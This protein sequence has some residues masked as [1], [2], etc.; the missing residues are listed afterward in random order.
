MTFDDLAQW[1]SQLGA[2]VKLTATAKSQIKAELPAFIRDLHPASA[3]AR[4]RLPTGETLGNATRMTALKCQCIFLARSAFGADYVKLHQEYEQLAKDTLFWVMRH[5]FNSA[6][7]KGIFCCPPCT[8]SLLPLYAA[9]SFRWVDCGELASNVL[10][11]LKERTSVF[12]RSYPKAYAQWAVNL[13]SRT[14]R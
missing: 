4:L 11:A 5:A 8:L 6:E 10:K 14:T 13:S 12:A 2:G 1:T 7:P 9:S 3:P